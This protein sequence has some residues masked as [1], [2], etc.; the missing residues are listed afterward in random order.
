MKQWKET[1]Y[2]LRRTEGNV[3]LIGHDKKP[4]TWTCRDEAKKAESPMWK[5]IKITKITTYK[6]GK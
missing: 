5:L 6:I 1:L 3:V 4:I 2:G